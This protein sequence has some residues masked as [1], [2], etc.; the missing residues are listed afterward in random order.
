MAL[1]DHRRR[2]GKL[3]AGDASGRMHIATERPRMDEGATGLYGGGSRR[4]RMPA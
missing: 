1:E 3:L 4:T 2:L